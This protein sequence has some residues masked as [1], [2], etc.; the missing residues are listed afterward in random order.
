MMC[1]LCD[2]AGIISVFF[3]RSGP[4]YVALMNGYAITCVCKEMGVRLR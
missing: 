1:K 4:V 2:G 3:E